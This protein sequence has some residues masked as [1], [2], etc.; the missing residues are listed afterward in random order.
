HRPSPLLDPA[1]G[2]A[3]RVAAGDG[4]PAVRGEDAG[5]AALGLGPSATGSA[6]RRDG[7]HIGPGVGRGYRSPAGRRQR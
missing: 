1:D 5:V 4:P 7:G 2:E 3:G 6:G